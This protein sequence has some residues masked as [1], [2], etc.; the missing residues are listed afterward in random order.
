MDNKKGTL[1]I[2][3]TPIGNLGDMTHRA[4]GVLN[5]V[6]LIAAEDT[7]TSG[8]LLQHFDIK[9]Q[10]IAYHEHNE[11]SSSGKLIAL[12]A[13]GKNIA[14][15]SD[16]GTPLISD[17]GYILVA[18]AHQESI[19]VEPVP[20]SSAVMAALSTAGLATDRFLYIGFLPSKKSARDK[21]LKDLQGVDATMVFYESCH[22]IE[23]S[24]KSFIDVFGEQRRVCFARE[25]TKQFETI[26]QTDFKNLLDFVAND[27]NQKRGE[28][29]LV[30]EGKVKVK[31]EIN[32]QNLDNLLKPLLQYLP[33]TSAAK[34]ASQYLQLKKKVCYQRAIELSQNSI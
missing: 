7:R 19:K 34:V 32:Y 8:K 18:Q 30:V 26:K 15:I 24:I 1:Y 4:I 31:D 12:L 23:D 33:P 13:Q 14:L 9:T 11:R 6:D 16:A 28:I 21:T 3:A 25:I 5:A 29:V 2:V 22:R 10:C 17:P 20:G 27:D